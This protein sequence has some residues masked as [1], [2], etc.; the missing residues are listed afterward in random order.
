MVELVISLRIRIPIPVRNAVQPGCRT[1]TSC[2]P[3]F[4][5]FKK[6]GDGSSQQEQLLLT[7][8]FPYCKDLSEQWF[9]EC[10]Y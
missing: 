2:I 4:V 10:K 5:P 8:L 7:Y 1:H 3:N 6:K 9:S